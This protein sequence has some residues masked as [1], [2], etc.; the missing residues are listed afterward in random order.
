MMSAAI[1]TLGRVAHMADA[2]AGTARDFIFLAPIFHGKIWGG[3]ELEKRFG[4]MIPRW[5][6]S[7][8][9][10]ASRPIPTVTVWSMVAS[11]TASTSR[12]CGRTITN[13]L[14]APRATASRCS[15]ILDAR[16]N[17][18]VQV[19]P[20]DAYAAEHE[21]GSLGKRECWY[22]IDCEPGTRIIVGQRAKS[23]ERSLRPRSRAAAGMTCLTTCPSIPV[24]SSAS[25]RAPCTPSWA[26]PLFWRPSSPPTSPIVY[27]YDR[28]QSDG[29]KRPLHEAIARR[30][31]LWAGSAHKAARLRHP[32]RTA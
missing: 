14:P 30:S 1:V 23:R 3:R 9:A 2:A 21:N 12:S 20:D 16:E 26:A 19:H 17:L 6:P 28:V 5:S 10:G 29:T 22:V 7:A 18:S 31:G 32:R 27:D 24:T 13:S 8:S 4:Y 25:S 11:L 15:S